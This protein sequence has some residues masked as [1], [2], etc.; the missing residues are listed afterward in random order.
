MANLS[1]QETLSLP[2]DHKQ[3]DLVELEAA[4]VLAQTASDLFQAQKLTFRSLEAHIVLGDIQRQRVADADSLARAGENYQA[5]LASLKQQSSSTLRYRASY[6]LGK[7]AEAR[8]SIDDALDWYDQ[9]IQTIADT[10]LMLGENELRGG[11]L[12]DKLAIF[13]S[14]IT[15]NLAQGNYDK[16]LHLIELARVGSWQLS[17]DD[18]TDNPQATELSELTPQ[19]LEAEIDDLRRQWRWYYQKLYGGSSSSLDPEATRGDIINYREQRY[20]QKIAELEAQ[21]KQALRVKRL[22]DS[23]T[24]F[25]HRLSDL[26]LE[27]LRQQLKATQCM[28]IYYVLDS[29]VI[30]LLLTPENTV[31]LTLMAS[32][33]NIFDDLK[34]LHFTLRRSYPNTDKLLHDLWGKLFKPLLPHIQ[35]Y[36]ELIIIP[37]DQLYHLPFHAL[38]DGEQYLLQR[39]QIHYMPL[40]SWVLQEDR[41]GWKPLE[42]EQPTALIMAYSDRESQNSIPGTLAEARAIEQIWQNSMER[43]RPSVLEPKL[44]LEE[45]AVSAHLNRYAHE[46]HL[47][48][49]ATHGKLDTENPLFSTLLLADGPLSLADVEMLRFKAKPLIVLSACE[50]GINNINKYNAGVQSISQ[51]FLHAGASMVLVSLWRVADQATALLMQSFHYHLANNLSPAQALYQAQSELLEC[52]QYSHPVYWAGWT[53]VG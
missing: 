16:V 15:L 3:P 14:A 7:L 11:Y 27:N 50:T 52:P 43:G 4:E 44:Y 42:L 10:L 47:F 38:Y 41:E 6:G 33:S 8:G 39:Y 9:A 21:I 32:R 2:E 5:V 34:R 25:D 40:A 24:Q 51:A 49:L 37:H 31:S 30:V 17:T 12:Y 53:L 28:L 18:D 35:A 19:Q 26:T 29:Q 23:Q 46:G 48:H 1:S 20:E 22:Y 45:E 36:N 13:Q